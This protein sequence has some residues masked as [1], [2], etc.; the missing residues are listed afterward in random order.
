MSSI[1]TLAAKSGVDV[2]IITPNTPDKKIIFETTRAHYQ[3]L[4]EEGVRIYQY[5]PGFV[6]G[7]V[8]V[9]DDRTSFVGS[10]NFDYRSLS[11]NYEC[12]AY[13]Y[14]KDFAKTVK[15]DMEETLSKSV[16]I[17]L[18]DIKSQPI[19]MRAMQ[20]VLRLLSPLL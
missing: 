2:R 11:W 17:T 6:H 16:E 5:K 3:N 8:L 18:Q 7:K 4:L 20:G 14:D 19:Y 10:I 15:G 9:T 1:L 13:V 12:G